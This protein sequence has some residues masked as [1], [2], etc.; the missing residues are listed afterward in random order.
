M[1]LDNVSHGHRLREK[2]LLKFIRLVSKMEPP[3]VVKTLLY[4]RDFF[5]DRFSE[6]VQGCLRGESFWTVGEREMFASFTSRLEA[7]HF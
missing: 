7:C 6:L 5:G 4:R 3:D 2:L 1:R